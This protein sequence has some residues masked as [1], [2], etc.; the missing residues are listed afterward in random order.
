MVNTC[1]SLINVVIGEQAKDADVCR[2]TDNGL[3]KMV[4]GQVRVLLTHATQ[5]LRRRRRGET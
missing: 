1:E 4:R 3:D 5:T 2:K